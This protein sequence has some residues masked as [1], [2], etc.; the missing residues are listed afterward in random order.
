MLIDYN[1]SKEYCS[2][3]TA[4]D[5]IREIVQNAI[6]SGQKYECYADE[7]EIDVTTYNSSLSP[8]VFSMGISQKSTDAIGKYGEGF[9][10]AML[11]LTRLGLNPMIETGK[12]RVKGLFRKHEFTGIETFCLDVEDIDYS[13]N[14]IEFICKATDIDL[15]EL[16]ARI[17]PFTDSNMKLPTN[18]DIMQDRPGEVFVNGLYVAKEDLVFGYNFAPNKIKLN[19]DRNMVDGVYWQLAKYYSNLGVDKADL[20]FDLLEKDAPDVQDLSYM[21]RDKKV[22]AELAR[23]F[24]NKYGEGAKIAKPGTIYYYSSGSISVSSSAARVYSAAGV[25]EAKQTIDKDAPDQVLTEWLNTHKRYLRRDVKVDFNKLIT[26]SKG[27]SKA[28][29]L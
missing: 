29:I 17:I 24:Y 7:Y 9:K 5:A 23:L 2:D 1:M 20:I 27:W 22:L 13:T 19:R 15:V 21:L 12:Y 28:S 10:I 25:S 6:D 11:V 4:V 16:K 3:W 18:V 14:S 8:E 26:R